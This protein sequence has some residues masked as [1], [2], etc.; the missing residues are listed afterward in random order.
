MSD[1][2]GYFADRP[3]DLQAL[4]GRWHIQKTSLDFWRTRFSATVTY[5]PESDVSGIKLLDEVRYKNNRGAE[6]TVVGYDS[7]RS[8]IEGQFL[9]RG[10][11]WY[12][13]FLQSEW[14]IVAHD[15]D[16]ADWAVTYFSKT[17]F[18]AAGMDI[19]SRSEV[20][21]DGKYQKILDRISGVSFLKPYLCKLYQIKTV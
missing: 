17:M 19:Y 12:L 4:S 15:D 21:D 18:T 14:G 5:T 1:I 10:K 3:V 6:K 8:G 16:Y 7:L 13:R 11:P 2:Q 9:W 20:L